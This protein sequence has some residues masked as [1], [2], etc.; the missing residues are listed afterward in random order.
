MLGGQAITELS[1][2]GFKRRPYVYLNGAEIA[3]QEKKPGLD[4]V[5]WISRDPI[6]GD[7]DITRDPLGGYI[8]GEFDVFAPDYATLKG[9]APTHDREAN[10]FDS[11]SGCT[12]DGIPIDCSTFAGLVNNGAVSVASVFGGKILGD[13]ARLGI[14]GEWTVRETQIGP[15]DDPYTVYRDAWVPFGASSDVLGVKYKKEVGQS[16]P[17]P[18][19]LSAQWQTIESGLNDSY[20]A[21][22]EQVFGAADGYLFKSLP[23]SYRAGLIMLG[24]KGNQNFEAMMAAIWALESN[25]GVWV[26]GDAGPAQLTTVWQQIDRTGS[27]RPK[28][29]PLPH[30]LGIIVGNAYGSWHGRTTDVFDGSPVDNILTLGNIVAFLYHDRG[31]DRTGRWADLPKGYGPGAAGGDP[32]GIGYSKEAMSRFGKYKE[33]FNC[34]AGR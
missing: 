1:S 8:G 20:L 33:F 26:G 19:A 30:P 28:A 15:P 4:E 11:G 5:K 29:K 3:R 21:C 31:V 24:G 27:A 12:L 9:D 6:T 14:G 25:F 18:S 16:A 2:E 17:R 34:L 10:P 23:G 22:L 7:D 32:G 13:V